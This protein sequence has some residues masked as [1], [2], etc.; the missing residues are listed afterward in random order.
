[1][2]RK[3]VL[4]GLVVIIGLLAFFFVAALLVG[5]YGS[6][7]VQFS[8]GGKVA[9]VEIRGVISQSSAVIDEIRQHL[10][11]SA[12]KAIVL[13]VD[14]PGGGV[15]PSQEIYREIQKIRAK[16]KLVVCS[17]GSVA[18]S[19]GY[20]IACASERI[21]ANPGTIT[22]SIGVVMQ[23][24]NVE[25]LMRK[26][27]IKGVVLKSGEYKDSGSPFRPMTPEEKALLQG[28]I[29]NVQQQFVDAVAEGRHLDKEKVRQIADGR[30]MT[31]EQAKQLGLVDQ[32]GNLQDAIEEAGK[33]AGIEGKPLVVYPKKKY[34]IW[35]ILL[36]DIADGIV[37]MLS[38]KG[39]ELNYRLP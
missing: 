22:G 34:T 28:V 19:G 3:R 13:R 20:Y 39:V 8:L 12:V 6:R 10:D 9:V 18:A 15:G 7:P 25:D 16:K 26:I 14:S 27:G 21:F 30:I 33:M 24:T 11:D 38:D 17:M 1:M 5:R 32:I 29:D 2:K 23:F 36:K 37:G 31:G 4:V 35:D